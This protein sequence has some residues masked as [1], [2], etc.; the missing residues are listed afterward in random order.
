M[1]CKI[2]QVVMDNVVTAQK[3][4]LLNKSCKRANIGRMKDVSIF[5]N[6]A[7][8]IDFMIAQT[9][10][11]VDKYNLLIHCM[12]SFTNLNASCFA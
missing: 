8:I 3:V 1:F 9:N 6:G 4:A 7:Q 2:F 12:F 10:F 11:A 5:F